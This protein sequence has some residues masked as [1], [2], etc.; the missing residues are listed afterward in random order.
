L[1]EQ[2]QKGSYA[3]D[4]IKTFL[5]EDVEELGHVQ[6]TGQKY[7][8]KIE[9]SNFNP[10][11]RGIL[12]IMYSRYPSK[13]ELKIYRKVRENYARLKGQFLVNLTDNLS[14]PTTPDVRKILRAAKKSNIVWLGLNHT[15]PKLVRFKMESGKMAWL[16]T[17]DVSNMKVSQEIETPSK[18]LKDDYVNQ[19]HNRGHFNTAPDEFHDF[20][21]LTDE[22][23]EPDYDEIEE[24]GEY[25]ER[26]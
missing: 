12:T 26:F 19:H 13:Q 6:K 7:I 14:G 10:A 5:R 2:T 11:L 21:P 4:I 20:I 23:E 22:E 8:S 24:C 17:L 3:M 9:R 1:P 18:Y 25:R 15:K 16:G